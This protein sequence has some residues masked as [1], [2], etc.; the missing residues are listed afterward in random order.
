MAR[1]R[2]IAFL[3]LSLS[4]GCRSAVVVAPKDKDTQTIVTVEQRPATQP[5]DKGLIVRHK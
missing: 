1:A 3:T 5:S 2:L 4:F